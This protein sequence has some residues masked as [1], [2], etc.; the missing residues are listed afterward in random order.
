MAGAKNKPNGTGHFSSDPLSAHP[1]TQ[2]PKYERENETTQ[3]RVHHCRGAGRG[4]CPGSDDS[5]IRTRPNSVE[6]TPSVRL[7]N[8]ASTTAGNVGSLTTLP[9]QSALRAW[10]VRRCR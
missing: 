6:P 8:G 5:G 10:I 2:R 9:H 3:G 4:D 7:H 1:A